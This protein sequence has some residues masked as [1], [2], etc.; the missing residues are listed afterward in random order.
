M[1]Y[2]L[3]ATSTAVGSAGASGMQSYN[4]SVTVKIGNTTKTFSGSGTTLHGFIGSPELAI[5][6]ADNPTWTQN[7]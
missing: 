2:K 5:N 7:V 4:W 3:T 6:S 1:H